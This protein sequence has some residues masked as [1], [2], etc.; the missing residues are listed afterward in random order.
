MDSNMFN[1]SQYNYEEVG[2][3]SKAINAEQDAVTKSNE[4]EY[5]ARGAEAVRMANQR[6][7]NFQKF[8]QL[9]KQGGQFAKELAE[10]N[11]ANELLKSQKATD[12]IDKELPSSGKK[13][14]KE[15]V[16]VDQLPSGSTVPI[17]QKPAGKTTTIDKKDDEQ[18]A[19]EELSKK[20][21]EAG[22]EAKKITGEL[23][24]EINQTDSTAAKEEYIAVSEGDMLND[25]STR[26]AALTVDLTKDHQG[27]VTEN[28]TRKVKLE[29]MTD[30]QLKAGG[31]SVQEAI[32]K[33]NLKLA[34]QLQRFWD[35]SWYAK[36]GIFKGGD[37]FL[38]RKQRLELLKKTNETTAGLYRK[39]V[40]GQYQK[41]QKAAEVT[42]QTDFAKNVNTDGIKALVG[43]GVDKNSGYIAQ[44]EY[45]TG[46]KN[47][48][49]AY[50]L[51]AIDLEKKIAD[52]SI[53]I[54]AAE[55]MLEQEFKHR[56]TGKLTT[57][58][59]SQPEFYNR[60]SKV[61]DKTKSLDYVNGQN[62]QKLDIQT[63]VKAQLDHIKTNM[64]GEINEEQLRGLVEEI[65]ND[66]NITEAHP[67][68]KELEPLLEYRTSEDKIDQDII[69]Q[70]EADF[71]DPDN[72]GHI[73]NLD[74]RLNEINDPKLR[75]QYRKKYKPSQILEIHK[76]AYKSDLKIVEDHIDT[77]LKRESN[78]A[79]KS[80]ENNQITYNAKKDFR[81]Q[82]EELI[83]KGVPPEVAIEQARKNVIATFNEQ[84]PQ[85]KQAGYKYLDTSLK[86]GMGAANVANRTLILK[87]GTVAADLI[88]DSNVQDDLLNGEKHLPGEKIHQE[89]LVN[90]LAGNGPM[91]L[92][93][94]QVG[95]GAKNYTS[96]E[97]IQMRGKALGLLKDGETSIPESRLDKDTKGLFC[98]MPGD[99][100]AMRGLI[101]VSGGENIWTMP[102]NGT[103]TIPSS[104]DILKS[105]EKNPLHES[106]ISPT[107]GE[108]IDPT[109]TP[110]GEVND[111]M[112]GK[113]YGLY[114]GVGIYGHTTGD[115]NKAIEILGPDILQ[116]P[117]D[118]NT[119]DMVEQALFM[120]NILGKQ[121]Y[122]NLQN[123][124]KEI[125]PLNISWQESSD[126][127]VSFDDDL[128]TGYNSP[129][130]LDSGIAE[131]LMNDEVE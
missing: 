84:D 119:Q 102:E 117:Y 5:A 124:Q 100:K 16:P 123:Y 67:F 105:L 8:G 121:S 62:E 32:Q 41:V 109:V 18:A 11:E 23:Q 35:Q 106:F 104:T 98:H 1:T 2:D 60:I 45:A 108:R 4:T 118:K 21:N 10:W 39:A 50:E 55:K 120:Y 78:V 92:Y 71:Y 131:N 129:W 19:E 46:V 88:N 82:V 33:G 14:K 72:G 94:L 114:G 26:G 70:L 127:A 13:V 76:D 63:K 38:G 89:A 111:L 6:S 43:D 58:E 91:P 90:Y 69:K 47:T 103:D 86:D 115:L 73:D 12:E 83:K 7:Q 112:K 57:L 99:G 30:A 125:K 24:N 75:E 68:Y 40:D 130:C 74:M 31:V 27:Y 17:D 77:K 3:F 66:L 56:G 42:R 81:I 122:M 15:V 79:I 20:S 110:L 116:M 37:N 22:V 48:P 96:H 113:G 51:A 101:N 95:V 80:G 65:T 59:Q 85:T 64:K 49:Y 107:G 34:A 44:F 54:S 61:I 93:Y 87:Q 97:V 25:Y 36:S 126:L 29:G 52:G 28:L 128:Y 53:T 9:I